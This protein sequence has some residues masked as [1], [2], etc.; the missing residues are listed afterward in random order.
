[1]GVCF[2]ILYWLSS[3]KIT[4]NIN[5]TEKEKNN[6]KYKF[7]NVSYIGDTKPWEALFS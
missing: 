7:V 3:S 4:R 2:I 6:E 5:E 1:M